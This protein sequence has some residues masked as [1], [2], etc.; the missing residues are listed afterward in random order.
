MI[1]PPRRLLVALRAFPR[2]F[3]TVRSAEI[4]A[5]FRE[6]ELAGDAQPYGWRALVDVVRAGWSERLRTH[7]PVGHFLRYRVLDGRL[8]PQW[9]RW[10]LDDVH[11]WYGLRRAVWTLV[12]LLVLAT[13]L[14]LGGAG[15][16]DSE[17]VVM[18]VVAAIVFGALFTPMHRR[19]TLR[20]H[21]YDPETLAWAPPITWLSTRPPRRRTTTVAPIAFTM[22][23]ALAVVAPFAVLASLGLIGAGAESVTRRADHQ[24]AATLGAVATALLIAVVTTVG[25]R[26]IARRFT[27]VVDDDAEPDLVFSDLPSA[28]ALSSA[29]AAIGVAA[30]VWP[31]TPL[32]VPVA[33]IVTTGVVPVLVVVGTDAHRRHGHGVSMIWTSRPARTEVLSRAGEAPPSNG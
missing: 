21:G 14:R 2:R 31:V 8:D 20:R 7:P 28:G 25:H 12:P 30:S 33:F 29:V 16:P 9:H 22:A 13:V 23:I 11:G 6:A 27:Q 3:R 17:F 26:R 32:I 5:T 10:M 15:Y 19:R 1:D 18:Y 24:V 4:V